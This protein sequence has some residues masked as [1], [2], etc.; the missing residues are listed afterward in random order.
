MPGVLHKYL[1][2]P[3]YSPPEKDRFDQE[4][5]ANG[6]AWTEGGGDTIVAQ[7]KKITSFLLRVHAGWVTYIHFWPWNYDA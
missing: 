2:P 5:T 1:G 3:Q 4:G 6:I 7:G